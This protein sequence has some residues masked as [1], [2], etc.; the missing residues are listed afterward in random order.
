MLLPRKRKAGRKRMDKGI[1][2]QD[3]FER[4]L[5]EF[6]EVNN[7]SS[8]QYQVVNCITKCRTAEMGAHVTECEKCQNIKI[9]YNSCKNRHCP[10]CQQG[11]EVDEWIDKQQENVLDTPYFHVVFTI[12]DELNP[13]VYSNQQVLYDALYHAAHKT[14]TELSADKKYLGAKLGYIC[15]LHTWGSRMNYHPH[16]HTIVLGGGLDENN[17]WKDKDG[18]LFFPYQVLSAVFKRYYL[19]EV[20]DL[21]EK[22]K[23]EYHG[24]SEIYKN[25]YEF[26]ELLNK[27]YT[28]DWIVHIKPAFNGAQSVI[29]YLGR[30]THRIAISNNRI[31]RIEGDDVVYKAKDYAGDGK[32]K[33]TSVKGSEF[34]R[35]FLMHVL[36][37]GFVR[38]RHY[39][40][41]SC[42][43][44]KDKMTLCRNILGC[45]QYLSQL[46]GRN[47][48]DKIKILYNRDICKCDKCGG[49]MIMYK[50]SG[51]YMLC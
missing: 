33:E 23:L 47:V 30:Y 41:I 1:T 43:C 22:N 37:R 7:F 19:D 39:G 28:K 21:R 34:I 20:K 18:K 14:L 38:I 35:M 26:K 32:L 24:S 29:N 2:I 51:R 46:R 31:I 17:K 40:L 10:M 11:I 27:V 6:A 36:P 25:H 49:H 45:K 42:R 48:V 16:L 50:V 12:P 5:P 44:K 9:H 13:L 8:R 15:V 4:F 3:V